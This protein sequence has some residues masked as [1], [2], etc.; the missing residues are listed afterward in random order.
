MKSDIDDQ[1]RSV[2]ELG[3]MTNITSRPKPVHRSMP[4]A[5]AYD[6][7]TILR[8][9][10]KPEVQVKQP[11]TNEKSMFFKF[12]GKDLENDPFLQRLSRLN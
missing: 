2:E 3:V 11:K 4:T 7:E 6:F 12:R 10:R 8:P 5:P 1:K 9:R